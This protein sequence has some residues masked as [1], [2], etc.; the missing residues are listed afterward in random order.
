MNSPRESLYAAANVGVNTPCGRFAI[1]RRSPPTRTCPAGRGRVD[2]LVKGGLARQR[3]HA[4]S[5]LGTPRV[6]PPQTHSLTG[7]SIGTTRSFH[8]NNRNIDRRNDANTAAES[9]PEQRQQGPTNP[10]RQTRCPVQ[11]IPA[12]G[13]SRKLGSEELTRTAR[14]SVV[15]FIFS[16]SAPAAVGRMAPRGRRGGLAGPD[17]DAVRLLEGDQ[18]RISPWYRW[19]G[20]VPAYKCLASTI[21]IMRTYLRVRTGRTWTWCRMIPS[22]Q[23]PGVSPSGE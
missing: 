11:V 9:S 20:A 12:A 4:R 7:P 2:H 5:V 19:R 3:H 1:C 10:G 16:V 23:A 21:S 15:Q 8:L 6:L 22:P 18:L 14:T 17:A 13:A